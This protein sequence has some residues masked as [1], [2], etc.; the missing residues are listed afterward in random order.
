VKKE[1]LRALREIDERKRREFY[2]RNRGRRLRAVVLGEE[3]VLTENYIDLRRKT[4]GRPGEV[5][6]ITL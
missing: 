5:V 1:R 4:D 2:E 6:E 3:R